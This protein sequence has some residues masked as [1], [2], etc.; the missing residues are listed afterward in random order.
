MAP[1]PKGDNV[2]LTYKTSVY[3][4]ENI[5][6]KYEWTKLPHDLSIYSSYHVQALVPAATINCL[7]QETCSARFHPLVGDGF[8]N[9]WTNNEACNYD[10]GD[11][12]KLPVN[13]DLCSNC[14]CSKLKP[15]YDFLCSLFQDVLRM[16]YKCFDCVCDSN[17][18]IMGRNPTEHV[19]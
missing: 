4:L 19:S 17:P 16:H 6:S 3:T 1:T 9:D 2:L 5:G 15:F 7:H 8:C 12:C 10:G 11:C 13:K 14:E 18:K